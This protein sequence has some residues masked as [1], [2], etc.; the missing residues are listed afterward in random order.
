MNQF[1]YDPCYIMVYKTSTLML[2]NSA[3]IAYHLMCWKYAKN[4]ISVC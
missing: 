3:V 4:K 1:N 2:N